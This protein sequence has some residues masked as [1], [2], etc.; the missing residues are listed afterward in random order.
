VRGGQR[1]RD[2]HRNGERLVQRHPASLIQDL[3]QGLAI[4][5]FGGDELTAVNLVGFVNRENA[6]VIE[7]GRRGGFLPE[8]TDAVRV[9]GVGVGENL[10]RND[11]AKPGISGA[12]HLAH[13]ALADFGED[14]VR[15]K[16]LA[17]LQSRI[18]YYVRRF[19]SPPELASAAAS[20]NNTGRP[21][22][23]VRAT[24]ET[25]T[26][27]TFI[28]VWQALD[29]GQTA[30]LNFPN[31]KSEDGTLFDMSMSHPTRVK[32]TARDTLANQYDATIDW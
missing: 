11:A 10:Q 2:L 28:Q 15:A 22:L 29:T 26:G 12:I 13:A 24:I 18:P 32:V 3:P 25:D 23:N 14:L 20:S 21:L 17:D 9:L 27:G 8:P 30:N 5:E 16:R 4:D 31:F 19:P 7:G 1:R 6:R